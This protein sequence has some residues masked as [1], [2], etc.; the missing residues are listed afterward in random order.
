MQ[1]KLIYDQG[2]TLHNRKA[3]FSSSYLHLKVANGWWLRTEGSSQGCPMLSLGI[4]KPSTGLQVNLVHH[5]SQL[6]PICPSPLYTSS[7]PPTPVPLGQVD[8][9]TWSVP[10]P[11]VLVGWPV[12]PHLIRFSPRGSVKSM[13]TSRKNTEAV[14]RETQGQPPKDWASLITSKVFHPGL[15]I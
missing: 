6:P 4:L 3:S 11:S 2:Y 15:D 8:I 14:F 1:A 10:P 13:G 7:F 12:S 9:L 5:A